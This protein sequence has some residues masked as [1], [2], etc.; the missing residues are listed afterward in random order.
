VITQI[1]AYNLSIILFVGGIA[2]FALVISKCFNTAG[3]A[4]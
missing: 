4:T 1:L 3:F 2:A